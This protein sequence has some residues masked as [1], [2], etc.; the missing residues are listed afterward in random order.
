MQTFEYLTHQ[1]G[2]K[3]GITQKRGNDYLTKNKTD[4]PR[5]KLAEFKKVNDLY[6]TVEKHTGGRFQ[7]RIG[8]G[9][10][11]G[12]PTRDG[13]ARDISGRPVNESESIYHLARPGETLVS[14][15]LFRRLPEEVFFHW[16]MEHRVYE[17]YKADVYSITAFNRHATDN[18]GGMAPV[19]SYLVQHLKEFRDLT[20]QAKKIPKTMR[21]RCLKDPITGIEE[22]FLKQNLVLDDMRFEQSD[23]YAAGN[24]TIHSTI[25]YGLA[26][27]MIEL[28]LLD[29]GKYKTSEMEGT[30]EGNQGYADLLRQIGFWQSSELIGGEY[31]NSLK[32]LP[33]NTSRLINLKK[34]RHGA[35]I[36]EY[37]PPLDRR[38][39]TDS[40]LYQNIRYDCKGPTAELFKRNT[41]HDFSEFY[42]G[43]HHELKI[44]L[45]IGQ[46]V[47]AYVR[48]MSDYASKLRAGFAQ[49]FEDP[50]H[51]PRL[52]LDHLE[53]SSGT[54][55]NP[56]MFRP[57]KFLILNENA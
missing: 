38:G 49:S 9:T 23:N 7:L 55:Y 22:I 5:S 41:G 45:E 42:D 43:N 2:E 44:I 20:K 35:L 39:V 13:T 50:F 12:T 52:A 51:L 34:A 31:M 32:I 40:L 17:K 26:K 54:I 6:D 57:M 14:K 53:I 37:C 48:F 4:I 1:I 21:D 24:S 3:F 19:D 15:G 30:M 16:D 33:E 10:G 18:L 27:V 47:N 11:R 29:E 8:I 25:C 56:E 28:G 46:I 36:A